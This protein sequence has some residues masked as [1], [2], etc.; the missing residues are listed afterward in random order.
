MDDMSKKYMYYGFRTNKGYGTK[1]HAEALKQHGI[2][3][4]HRKSFKPVLASSH[5]SLNERE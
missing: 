1:G 3:E 5:P 2:C 4:I